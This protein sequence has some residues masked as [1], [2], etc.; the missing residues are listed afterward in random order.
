MP[1]D[2]PR[3][4]LCL[5]PRTPLTDCSVCTEGYTASLSFTCV[6]CSENSGRIA[7]ASILASL[8]VVVFTI[9]VSYL[10]SGE[11]T[12]EDR[13]IAARVARYIPLQSIKIVFV[14]W[15]ILTQVRREALHSGV[16]YRVQVSLSSL[17]DVL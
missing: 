2:G 8:A 11:T 1:D 3:C 12:D 9:L 4:H 15:Q 5:A 16:V 7:L 17:C 13:G 10:L 14:A 6:K